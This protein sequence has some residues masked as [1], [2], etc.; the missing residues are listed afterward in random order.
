[1]GGT[2][3][4]EANRTEDQ[5]LIDQV[6]LDGIR[7]ALHREISNR[8]FSAKLALECAQKDSLK[9]FRDQLLIAQQ[10]MHAAEICYREWYNL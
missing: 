7:T 8:L 3:M 6:K 9:D 4:T 1:M 2:E 10:A 5:Q